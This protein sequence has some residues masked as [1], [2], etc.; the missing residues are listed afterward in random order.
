MLISVM[1]VDVVSALLSALEQAVHL[2][3]FGVRGQHRVGVRLVLA[4]DV[5]QVRHALAQFACATK[6]FSNRFISLADSGT[7]QVDVVPLVRVR[8]QD[9]LGALPDL[10]R[11]LGLHV[12]RRTWTPSR[13]CISGGV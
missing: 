4:H 6:G 3:A 9:V 5:R 1:F 8:V 12:Y 7:E 2:G 11:A 13:R 10:L